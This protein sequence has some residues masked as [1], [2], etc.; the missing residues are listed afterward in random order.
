[1]G[2]LCGETLS[3]VRDRGRMLADQFR[4]G[5]F[6]SENVEATELRMK[7][8]ALAVGLPGAEAALLSGAAHPFMLYLLTCQ[9]AGHLATV[10]SDFLAPQFAPYRHEDLLATFQP[11]LGFIRAAVAEAVVE[12]W[13]STPLRLVNGIFEA[14]SSAMLDDVIAQHATV[15]APLAAM[16]LR[17]PPGIAEQAVWHWGDNCVIGTSS[18]MAGLLAT[19]VSGADRRRADRLPGLAPPRGMILF[20]LGLDENAV[21]PGEPLQLIERFISEGRPSE[22]I[23]YTKRPQ[24][25]HEEM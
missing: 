23:L 13:S 8:Q 9:L 22:A 19:R 20:A 18:T 25:P 5:F 17:I 7:A 4:A 3:L 14:A 1:L 11:V 10:T 12:S 6:S 2:K 15:D 16:A 24:S 21:K